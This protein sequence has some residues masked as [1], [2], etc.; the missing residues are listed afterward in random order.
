LIKSLKKF[1]C[2]E[3]IPLFVHSGYLKFCG[4]ESLGLWLACCC[5]SAML[6]RVAFK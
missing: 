2:K 5:A 1:N 6:A 3:N 4:Q